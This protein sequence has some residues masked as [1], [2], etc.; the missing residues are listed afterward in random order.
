VLCEDYAIGKNIY[1]F[2]RVWLI[3]VVSI[4]SFFYISSRIKMQYSFTLFV[5]KLIVIMFNLLHGNLGSNPNIEIAS[6]GKNGQIPT[7]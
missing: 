2:D 6:Q 3:I 7:K 1:E 4:L 5:L